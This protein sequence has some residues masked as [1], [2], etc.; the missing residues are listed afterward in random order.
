MYVFS[1]YTPPFL[2]LIKLNHMKTLK[3]LKTTSAA[4]GFL[5]LISMAGY[6][7]DSFERVWIWLAISVALLGFGGAFKK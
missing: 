5:M 7:G 4:I 1:C 2:K 3:I 6:V